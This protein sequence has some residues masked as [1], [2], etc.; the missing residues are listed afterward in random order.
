MII[1]SVTVSIENE[2]AEEWREWMQTHH[3]PEVMATGYF[4]SYAMQRILEPVVD[5]DRVNYNVLYEIESLEK[6]NEYQSLKAPALQHEHQKR[7]G[8]NALSIR[9]VM[10]RFATS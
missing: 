7:Y 10:E 3:I 6:L 2:R 4:D 8:E 5:P 9:V 1:Y